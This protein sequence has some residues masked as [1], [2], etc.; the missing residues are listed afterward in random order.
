[1]DS[2]Q[3]GYRGLFDRSGLR[4]PISEVR[5]DVWTISRKGRSVSEPAACLGTCPA[6]RQ[7]DGRRLQVA[8]QLLG[9]LRPLGDTVL[10]VQLRQFLPLVLGRLILVVAGLTLSFDKGVQSHLP[11]AVQKH[12]QLV[13]GAKP[14]TVVVMKK[15]AS[16][17]VVCSSRLV[18]GVG[19]FLTQIPDRQPVGRVF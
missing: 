4:K 1:M 10:L 9:V 2:I 15:R 18:K 16:G 5:E 6:L 8:D 19:K 7:H 3:K 12:I 14:R 17:E 13:T 11:F